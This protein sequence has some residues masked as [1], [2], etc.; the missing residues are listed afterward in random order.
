[1]SKRARRWLAGSAELAPGRGSSTVAMDQRV[2]AKPPS[3]NR[4]SSSGENACAAT[5]GGTARTDHSTHSQTQV[6]LSTATAGGNNSSSIQFKR[7]K[8]GPVLGDKVHRNVLWQS[9]AG[10]PIGL[11]DDDQPHR[12]A[13]GAQVD[14]GGQDRLAGD[15]G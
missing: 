14:E 13:G 10:R 1:M 15:G 6:V 3:T 11:A 12:V 4:P 7:F 5:S 8:V 9:H 2:T